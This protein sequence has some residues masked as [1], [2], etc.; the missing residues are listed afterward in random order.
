[1]S[2]SGTALLNL[3]I[4]TDSIHLTSDFCLLTSD[5][6]LTGSQIATHPV[7]TSQVDKLRGCFA[8]NGH[9]MLASR[10]KIAA[11]RQFIQA[12]NHPR[13]FQQA[14]ATLP[15]SFSQLG[16]GSQKPLGI[17]V[18]WMIKNISRRALLNHL[19]GI[20]DHDPLSNLGND[21]KIMGN[22]ENG[23]TEIFF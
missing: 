19:A 9:C 4:K 17:R 13:N 1:M 18:L 15:R 21:A 23:G 11:I 3:F 7:D 12:G 14:R 6:L 8:A 16:N 2:K 5:L 10:V 20:H 22:N